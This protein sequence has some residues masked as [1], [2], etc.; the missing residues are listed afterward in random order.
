MISIKS[1]LSTKN[2]KQFETSLVHFKSNN[3]PFSRLKQAHDKALQ[4]NI[5]ININIAVFTNKLIEFLDK[6]KL[7]D[8]IALK[9]SKR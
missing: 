1:N 6:E 9:E 7:K 5:F 4:S 8:K 3:D 2:V